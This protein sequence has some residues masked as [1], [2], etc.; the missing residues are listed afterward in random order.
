MAKPEDYLSIDTPENVAFDYEVAGIGSR[1]LAALVDTLL[2]I[3]LQIIVNLTLFLLADALFADTLDW[4]SGLQ[5]WLFAVFG[6][7]AFA[8]LWGYYVF[9]EMIWNGQSP[10]K[11]WA[12]LR[13]I[14]TD[15]TPIT[16]SESLIRNLVRL[17]D[18]LPVYYGIGV[19]AM[20]I[21]QQS[22]R[23]GDLAAGTLVVH[24]RATVTLESLVASP[25][26]L[27]F[28]PVSYAGSDLPIERLTSQDI[29]MAEEFLRR[30]HQL[31]N[32]L[33]VASRIARAL[34]ER[35]DV[36]AS[37]TGALSA[38]D[39]ILKVVQASRSRGTEQLRESGASDQEIRDQ[40]NR[41]E[42]SA[43]EP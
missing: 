3:V 29:Q 38:Q 17:I 18:F 23:L 14:R 5:T 7:M 22:R 10:G 42:H 20:F 12:G 24:D 15:G 19:V 21:N 28:D 43:T 2:I 31:S 6:L 40:G 32:P 25:T 26:S 11:R 13:V 34:L 8:F 35:M 33:A 9:F 27:A 39:L 4:E 36:P 30:Q 1:F 16:F 41:N 37:Q